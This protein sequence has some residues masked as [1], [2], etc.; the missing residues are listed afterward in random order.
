MDTTVEVL[1][2]ERRP[3]LRGLDRNGLGDRGWLWNGFAVQA[4]AFDVKL[5]SFRNQ[6]RVSSRV[7]P[8]VTQPGRSGT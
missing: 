7:L 8:V 1:D 2:G 5:D 6:R 3:G 4:H